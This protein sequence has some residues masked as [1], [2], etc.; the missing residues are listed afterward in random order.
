[1]VTLSVQEARTI[2]NRGSPPPPYRTDQKKG[3]HHVKASCRV[4]LHC[5]AHRGSTAPPRR[6][7]ALREYHAA[8]SGS[9]Q[10]HC[11]HA[12]EGEIMRLKLKAR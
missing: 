7:P 6:G 8:Y 3:G 2:L 12:I 1:M 5:A 9:A 10:H 4:L 11:R